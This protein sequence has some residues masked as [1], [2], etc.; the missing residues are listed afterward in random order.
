MEV[1]KMPEKSFEHKDI[2]E[3]LAKLKEETPEYPSKLVESRKES[4]LK[5]VLDLGSSGKGGD[6]GS[7]SDSGDEGPKGGASGTGKSG[8]SGKPGRSTGPGGSSGSGGSSRPGS[9]S[10]SGRPGTSAG[11]GTSALGFGISLKSA[12]TFGAVVLL[13]TAAY[14]FREQIAEYLAENN[15][16]NAQETAA[17]SIASAPG[18]AAT[19]APANVITSASQAPSSG[20]VIT[21]AAPGIGSNNN[22]NNNNEG[23]PVTAGKDTASTGTTPEQNSSRATIT[24]TPEPPR[25]LGSAM[26][27][28]ICILRF[29][30]ESCQ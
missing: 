18:G 21:E 9:L 14:I 29:G 19:E 22:N 20:T 25:D 28:L 27:Y 23:V 10:G 3:L 15:I 16:T 26:R 30:R 2:V 8:G 11:G 5:Q 12:L 4:F 1:I 24:S 13:L 7:G 17:P 6:S